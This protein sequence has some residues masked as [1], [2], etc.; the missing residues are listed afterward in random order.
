MLR[1]DFAPQGQ[2]QTDVREMMT[3]WGGSDELWPEKRGAV[4]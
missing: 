2:M 1:Q 4:A 3:T